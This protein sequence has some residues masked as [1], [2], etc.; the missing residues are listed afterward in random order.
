MSNIQ[1]IRQTI[2]A[3]QKSYMWEVEIQ[4]AQAGALGNLTLYAKT[5][6]IPQSS[7][8]QMTI[9][10]KAGKTHFAGR[11]ASAHTLTLT[12]W[13][14]ENGTVANYMNEWYT[15]YVSDPS[16]ANSTDKSQYT[17]EIVLRL[18]DGSD[19]IETSRYR[20]TKAWPME[21][22]EQSLAYDSTE[23]L[24]LSVIF[25]YDEKFKEK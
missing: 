11:D 22:G 8:E 18:K 5:A 20:M 21:I 6:S 3:P 9:N 7:V 24:E 13:D 12:F 15:G 14:D 10:H 1:D 19:T 25:S 4:G 16:T 2:H 17:A 23:P